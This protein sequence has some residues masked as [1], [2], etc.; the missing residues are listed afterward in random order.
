MPKAKAAWLKALVRACMDLKRFRQAGAALARLLAKKPG[1]AELWRLSASLK[2]GQGDHAQAAADLEVA[3]HLSP[4]ARKKW[5]TLA[6]LY[7]M[8]GVPRKAARYYLRSFGPEPSAKQLM[9]LAG[10][11][12]EANQADKALEA[13]R[14][15]IKL[16]PAAKSWRF[17]AQIHMQ[18]KS[19]RQA[20]QAYEEGARLASRNARYKLMA[21]YCALQMEDYQQALDHLSQA[22][23]RAKPGSRD[24]KEAGRAIDSLRQYLKARQDD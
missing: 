10:V 4:P 2:L 17:I 1:D 24:A 13:A 16:K 3:Y 6:E 8:A 19:Y 14:A 22:A 15:S 7:R 21:G 5:R 9:L 18:A 11:Y 23:A 20:M 12:G